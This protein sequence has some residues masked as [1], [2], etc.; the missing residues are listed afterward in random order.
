MNFKTPLRLI[1]LAA[2]L[3]LA[4]SGAKARSTAD[5]CDRISMCLDDTELLDEGRRLLDSIMALPT[6]ERDSLYPHLLYLD[7]YYFINTGDFTS[8]KHHLLPLLDRLPCSVV[9]ELDISVPQDLGLCYRREGQNDSA[10]YYYDRALQAA[11]HHDDKEWQAAINLNIGVLYANLGRHKDAEPYIEQA[12]KL[13]R[14]VDDPYTELCALQLLASEKVY[15]KK[16][17][18]ARTYAEQAYQLAVQSESADWQLRCL[19][20]MIAVYDFLTLPDSVSVTLQRGNALLPS[21]PAQ[22]IT[23][24]GY[25]T[26]R[27][28]YYYNHR[29]WQQAVDSETA[30]MRTY[31]AYDHLARCYEQMGHWQQACM[32]KDSAA[33]CARRMADAEFASQLAEFNARY[34]TMEKDLEIARLESQRTRFITVAT[35]GAIVLLLLLVAAWLWLRQRRYRREAR[36]RIS[37]LEDERRRTAR[38][39]HDGVCNDLL[40]LEM[41]CTTGSNSTTDTVDRLREVRLRARTLSHQLMPPEFTHVTLSS[42]LSH[43]AD[44]ISKDTNITAVCHADDADIPADSAHALYRIAQEHTANIVKGA[45][46]THID[47]TLTAGDMTISDDGIADTTHRSPEGDNK[48]S[49][50]GSRTISDRATAI[51]ATIVQSTADGRNILT[52]RL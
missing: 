4:L 11:N 14:Q 16:Y 5:L 18:D 38:E 26:A 13:V 47:I 42:L 36:L 35:A 45:T 2:F 10:L 40:A 12:V 33:V 52:V 9:P 51:G 50:I 23:A 19:T 41:Q 32:Y 24:M 43:L 20:P 28:N 22:G 29:Q 21:V 46:A 1:S 39:L 30:G 44:A 8:A 49:G 6:T 48:R 25:I 31:D 7:A 17:A 34:Q 3:A 27:G 37:T 15:L